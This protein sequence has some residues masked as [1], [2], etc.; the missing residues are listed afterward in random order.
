MISFAQANSSGSMYAIWRKDDR[1]DLATPPVVA[2]GDEGG[3]HLVAR[4]V[5]ELI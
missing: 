4:D 3:I 5:R 2:L 1:A